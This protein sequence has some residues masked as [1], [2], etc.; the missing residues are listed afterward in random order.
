MNVKNYTSTIS[1]SK[2]VSQIEELLAKAG[3]RHVAKT[4]DS[5]GN[6]EG[7]MFQIFQDGSPLAIIKLPCK[8]QA[9][10]KIMKGDVR[11]P[12]KGT[13]QR[14]EAQAQRTAWKIMYDWIYVQLS[15]IK[16]EQAELAEIFLPYIYDPKTDETL[17][18][19]QL[20]GS[21]NVLPERTMTNE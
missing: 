15:L 10:N 18:Q 17:Y 9:I 19:K 21:I 3:A 13:Y 8:W 2:S 7:I 12:I 4:Y 20:N 5:D 14:I 6:L 1:V 16:M 11:K